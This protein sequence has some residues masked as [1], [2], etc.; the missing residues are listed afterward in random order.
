MDIENVAAILKESAENSDGKYIPWW[1]DDF[2]HCE[3]KKNLFTME[4]IQQIEECVAGCE[5]NCLSKAVQGSDYTLFHFLVWHNFYQ[6]VKRAL[7][8]G[9]DANLPDS[10]GIG[11]TPLL[12]ACCRGNFAMA[13]LLLDCGADASCRDI[14]G[15]TCFHYLAHIYA[16]GMEIPENP[17]YSLNQREAIVRLLASVYPAADINQ[18]D[19]QGI[20]PI[21]YLIDGKNRRICSALIGTFLEKGA[22]PYFVDNAGGTLLLIA[23]IDGQITASLLLMKYKDLVNQATKRGTTPILAAANLREEG[24]CIA[25]KDHG[26]QGICELADVDTI[27]LARIA[28]NAFGDAFG[29]KKDM[30][31]FSLGMYLSKKL[32]AIAQEDDDY[33]CLEDI[34]DCALKDQEARLFDLFRDTNICFT[35]PYYGGA[36]S[37]NCLRDKCMEYC[38]YTSTIEK[39]IRMGVDMESAVIKGR[40]PA[41]IL[42]CYQ[43]C[44]SEAFLLFSA[45]SMEQ[46]DN[47]G[48]AAIH[49]AARF[50]NT[51]TLNIMLKKGVN[52]N[53]AQDAPAEAG[54]TPLHI[55]CIYGKVEMVKNLLALG[56]DDTIQNINGK[57][58]AHYVAERSTYLTA[59]KR[60]EL[61]SLLPHIDLAGRDGETPLMLLMSIGDSSVDKIKLLEIL[62]AKGA[63]VNCSDDKGNTPL[64]LCAQDFDE[65]FERIKMLCQAGAEINAIDSEGNNVL[66]Y[67]L[68]NGDLQSAKYLLKQGADYN[69][70]NLDNVSPAQVAIEKGYDTLLTWMPEIH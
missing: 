58:P 21:V 9:V 70:R 11:I 30:D 60:E 32:I 47:T 38:R 54:N 26:A 3:Y 62:L 67:T 23:I 61:F 65:R 28:N 22:D 2:L 66:Y 27:N 48:R 57:T 5:N 6:A 69:R 53:L 45:E 44:P 35:E 15:R 52:I 49:Y 43:K 31:L 29:Q 8:N 33:G 37:V 19:N 1:E 24:L 51:D 7:E 50:G 12:L 20:P 40:T 4:E 34:L 14:K 17:K 63:R 18:K 16:Q 13:K 55:A 59:E 42:A 39:L 46:S 68:D 56:A 36:D 64:L 25:L 41:N 10:S